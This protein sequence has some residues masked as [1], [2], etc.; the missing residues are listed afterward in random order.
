MV[1][2]PSELWT[3]ILE[4]VDRADLKICRLVN[5]QIGAAASKPLFTKLYISRNFDSLH[6]AREISRHPSYSQYVKTV[7]Y[8]IDAEQ[9]KPSYPLPPERLEHFRQWIESLDPAKQ[10]VRSL[11]SDDSNANHPITR[12]LREQ[13]RE[14]YELQQIVAQFPNL[15]AIEL[16]GTNK[17]RS[18]ISNLV[19]YHRH[20]NR[21][22]H[23][24]LSDRFLLMLLVLAK[25]P[26]ITT[27]SLTLELQ[28][29]SIFQRISSAWLSVYPQW[30]RLRR[31]HLDIAIAWEWHGGTGTIDSF[32][33]FLQAT[34]RLQV[35]IL[36]FGPYDNYDLV[37]N[38]EEAAAAILS[39]MC[40][41]HLHTLSLAGFIWGE[42]QLLHFFR[43]HTTLRNLR[44]SHLCLHSGSVVSIIHALHEYP[45]LENLCFHGVYEEDYLDD[46]AGAWNGSCLSFADTSNSDL[47]DR[48]PLG[49]GGGGG[50]G[51]EEEPSRVHCPGYRCEE[52]FGGHGEWFPCDG[53]C[54]DQSFTAIFGLGSE[55][56]RGAE[57]S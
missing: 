47:P 31:I 25:S 48:K 40:W 12:T 2:L 23:Q 54:M 5:W 21:V 8:H 57:V 1:T 44:L 46:E 42:Q 17:Q 22:D 53:A 20:L 9:D 6:R 55:R 32:T 43:T 51:E 14:G 7:G 3:L 28:G 29:W 41:P 24:P 11:Q 56:R 26:H 15:T 18:Q 35:L 37:D 39:C 36:D 38:P 16:G 4:Y 27:T 10:K 50:G 13:G 45:W 30:T 33:R 49:E 19:P 52:W 34:P